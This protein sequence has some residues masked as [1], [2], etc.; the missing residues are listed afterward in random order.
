MSPGDK[1]ARDLAA[2]TGRDPRA[3]NARGES[4]VVSALNSA[5]SRFVQN[6]VL[7]DLSPRIHFATKEEIFGPSG[8]VGGKL[9]NQDNNQQLGSVAAPA[10]LSGGWSVV[11][12]L[13]GTTP[14]WAVILGDLEDTQANGANGI[15]VTGCLVPGPLNPSDPAWKNIGTAPAQIWLKVGWLIASWPTVNSAVIECTPTNSGGG[16]L[17]YANDASTPPNHIQTFARYKLG[18]VLAYNVD[19]SPQLNISALGCLKLVNDG[20]TAF[21]S[22]GVGSNPEAIP[23]IRIVASSNL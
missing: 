19:G 14:Q 3:D 15:S 2:A 11:W 1:T 20:D 16:A 23:L 17:E 10:G 7:L 13:S 8:R 5:R 21:D 22:G 9:A 12:Q 4:D 6:R 18:E